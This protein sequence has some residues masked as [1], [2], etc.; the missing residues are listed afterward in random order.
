MSNRKKILLIEDDEVLKVSTKEFLEEEGFEVITAVDGLE[1]IHKA[2]NQVPDIILADIAMPKLDGYQVYN[3]LQENSVTAIIPFIFVTAKISNEDVRAGMQLGADDYITKPFDYDELLTTIQTRLK[4][5]EKLLESTQDRYQA[6]LENTLLGVYIITEGFRFIYFNNK[7]P[8][9]FG[10]YSNEMEKLTL[11]DVIS[12]GDKDEVA[13]K[14]RKVLKGI[15][16]QFTIRC[17]GIDRKNQTMPI[18]LFAGKTTIKGEPGIIGNILDINKN[19]TASANPELK[20]SEYAENEL[21]TAVDFIMQNIEG[22]SSDKRQK[23]MELVSPME[24]SG[25]EK[26][27][28]IN[29]TTRELEVLQFICEGYTNQEIAQKLF[30]SQRTVDGHRANLMNK[31][32]TRNTAEL[33]M[34]AVKNKLVSV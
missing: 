6:L 32:L 31:T 28:E 8:K 33:V 16:T 23:L 9:M 17:V 34:Y 12:A 2:L 5:R 18:E 27:K 15:Q 30:I 20:L 22:I 26:A 21:N 29:I 19:K 3:T 24:V 4:K 14:M 7:L 11:L 1:G 25:I 10:Y 13:E